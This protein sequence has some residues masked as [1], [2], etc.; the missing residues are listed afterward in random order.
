MKKIN[1]WYFLWLVGLIYLSIY[2]INPKLFYTIGKDVIDIFLKQILLIL[3]LVFVFMFIL[4]FFIR[5]DNVQKLIKDSSS[6]KKYTFSVI[7]WILSS[8]PVYM[9]YPFLQ[10][11]KKHWLSYGHIAT[12]I[13]ARAIKLWFIPV[14]A[15]YFWL[16][17]TIIFNLVLIFISIIIWLVIDKI[18]KEKS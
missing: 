12:F 5:K 15:V 3:I 17:Y 4:N 9:W 11:L 2:F 10:E 16:K 6:K 13:Y 14:M 7:W 8:W 1:K 18:I